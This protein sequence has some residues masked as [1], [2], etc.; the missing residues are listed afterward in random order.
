MNPR[1]TVRRLDQLIQSRSI[2][3]HPFYVAWQRGELTRDQLATYATAY[4]PHVAA[5]PRYLTAA[6]NA[7]E[8][9][10]VRAELEHN[11]ADELSHPKP[12][13]ELWLDFAAG[14]GLD[15]D[16]VTTAAPR[17]PAEN[18]V[19][20]FDHLARSGTAR[21]LAALYAYESQQ[22]EVSREKAIGLR[23]HYGV[24][25]P[26]ALA[27]FAV[28]TET[29]IHH[30]DGERRALSRCLAAGAAP[31]AVLDAAREALDAYWGLLD[32]ICEDAAIPLSC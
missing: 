6:A 25:D 9:P 16:T 30:R 29:D 1:D 22:P 18:I 12:H 31:D 11:L 21:A 8:D 4:Y 17:P 23:R 32:G 26:T 2:L 15:R 14:L 7:A 10:R 24:D 5:F 3:R 28:H 20:T 27:Y 19:A 13:P